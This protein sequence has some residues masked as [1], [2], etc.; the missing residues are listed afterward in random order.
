[1][2]FHFCVSIAPLCL[3]AAEALPNKTHLVVRFCIRHREETSRILHVVDMCG[4]GADKD[5]M[6]LNNFVEDLVSGPPDLGKFVDQASRSCGLLST[7]APLLVGNN[8]LFWFSCVSALKEHQKDTKKILKMLVRLKAIQNQCE[9]SSDNVWDA[10]PLLPLGN[11]RLRKEEN[12]VLPLQARVRKRNP[13]PRLR[14]T[15]EHLVS[16]SR[17]QRRIPRK[18]T[19][20]K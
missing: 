12:Q 1:M 4:S 10:T 20:L 15:G 8:K 3:A 2:Y 11:W 19:L 13:T 9:V 18:R 16:W 14:R 6:H 7:L 5:M 17:M